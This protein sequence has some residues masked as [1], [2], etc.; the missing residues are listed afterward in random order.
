MSAVAARR[1]L[2]LEQ[3]AGE[4]QVSVRQVRRLVAAGALGYVELSPKCRR[5]TGEQLE[6][7]IDAQSRNATPATLIEE[8][9]S[10]L[11]PEPGAG[12][13]F[14]GDGLTPRSRAAGE[15]SR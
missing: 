5:V 6:A 4:L 14:I 3:V 12:V 2:T 11:M 9:E 7:F 10:A 1:L 8:A 15:W 13:T